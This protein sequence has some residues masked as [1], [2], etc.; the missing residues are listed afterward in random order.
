MGCT[1]SPGPG[2]SRRWTSEK[3]VV[4]GAPRVG[5]TSFVGAASD[6][7]PARTVESIPTLDRHLLLDAGRIEI[8]DHH[9]LQL[10]G[11]PLPTQWDGLWADV[12]RCALGAVVL[13][14]P[15]DPTAC[16]PAIEHL[17]QARLP[18][19]VAVT[20]FADADPDPHRV[21]QALEV[22][23]DRMSVCDPRSRISTRLA[24]MDVVSQRIQ[25]QLKETTR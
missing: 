18:F 21:A 3:I 24:L 6:P 25:Q 17:E 5:K 2:Y 15:D 8:A 20:Q 13:V 12:T 22:S 4:T 7:T 23:L 19:H 1:P 10:T 16:F 9:V 14:H 11:A